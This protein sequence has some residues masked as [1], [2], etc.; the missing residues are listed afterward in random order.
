MDLAIRYLEVLK[1]I[2]HL[3]C[4]IKLSHRES[5]TPQFSYIESEYL[6]EAQNRIDDLRS[7][8]QLNLRNLAAYG[9]LNRISDAFIR[10]YLVLSTNLR[11]HLFQ[12]K[13]FSNETIL[14]PPMVDGLKQFI[15]SIPEFW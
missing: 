14:G 13:I 8:P 1:E 5:N 7:L 9:I 3:I 10:H 12:D 15:Q 2:D 11:H 6:K 4:D